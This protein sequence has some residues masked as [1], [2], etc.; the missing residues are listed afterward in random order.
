MSPEKFNSFGFKAYD[1]V[2]V[3]YSEGKRKLSIRVQLQ[4]GEAL[5][6]LWEKQL[7]EKSKKQEDVLIRRPSLVYVGDSPFGDIIELWKVDDIKRV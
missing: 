3:V 1:W 6:A 4:Q 7:N 5:E 2:E